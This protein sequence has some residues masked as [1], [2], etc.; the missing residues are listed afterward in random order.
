MIQRVVLSVLRMIEI[1]KDSLHLKKSNLKL[2]SSVEVATYEDHRMAMA[3]APLCLKTDLIILDS[4]VVSKSY[5]TFW[6]D[7]DV[8]SQNT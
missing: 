3:F 1:T 2:C 4:N 7:W 5:P 6:K 8:Y